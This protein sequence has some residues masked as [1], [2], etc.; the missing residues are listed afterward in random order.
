MSEE[1]GRKPLN[2]GGRSFKEKV[3]KFTN[4]EISDLLNSQKFKLTRPKGWARVS[5]MHECIYTYVCIK[6]MMQIKAVL[7]SFPLSSVYYARHV[8]NSARISTCE[9]IKISNDKW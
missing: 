3:E 6:C 1:C 5:P 4:L 8:A 2:I 9:V 7:S